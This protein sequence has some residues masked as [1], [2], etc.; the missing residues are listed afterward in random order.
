MSAL[1]CHLPN[2][3]MRSLK[4][5]VD[6]LITPFTLRCVAAVP[7]YAGDFLAPLL[8]AFFAQLETRLIFEWQKFDALQV[9]R[10]EDREVFA[11]AFFSVYKFN[12]CFL[13]VLTVL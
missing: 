12:F 9:P 11:F 3:D 6:K 4:V 10:A 5:M 13:R 8:S 1:F 7:Q 2:Q